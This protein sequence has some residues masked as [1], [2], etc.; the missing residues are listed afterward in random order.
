M[1]SVYVRYDEI[2][3]RIC[4]VYGSGSEQQWVTT[5]SFLP[6]ATTPHLMLP[7]PSSFKIQAKR[8]TA[9]RMLGM[10]KEAMAVY[11]TPPFLHYII[12]TFGQVQ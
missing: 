10:F 4:L 3:E 11:A 9:L 6:P 8:A 2:S 5:H 12:V 1:R 7:F